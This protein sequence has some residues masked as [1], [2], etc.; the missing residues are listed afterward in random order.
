[1]T[2]PHLPFYFIRHGETDWNRRHVF[3]GKNDI[4]LNQRGIE[5]SKLAAQWLKDEPIEHIVTS[6]L[7]RALKT[8]EIIAEV[9]QVPITVIDSLKECD[10]GNKEGQPVDDH[11]VFDKWIAGH[12]HEGA[13]RACDFDM[14]VKCALKDA[15]NVSESVLIVAHGGVYCSIQRTLSLSLVN[16]KNCSP[17]Y[18]R[19]PEHPRHSWLVHDIGDQE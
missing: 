1:M 4:P 7:S 13:E 8:A 11:A 18:H 19:P 10:W 2:I 6:P 12:T 14:R 17:V 5:Q 3:M 15:L 9:L 16:I